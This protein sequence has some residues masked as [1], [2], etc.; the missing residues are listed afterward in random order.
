MAEAA[1]HVRDVSHV[2]VEEVDERDR[3]RQDETAVEDAD[4]DQLMTTMLEEYAEWLGEN[5]GNATHS[6]AL[7]TDEEMEAFR[8]RI[9]LELEPD[10][11]VLP[12]V[13][14]SSS[15]DE[16]EDDAGGLPDIIDSSSDEEA[17]LGRATCGPARAPQADN[18]NASRNVDRKIRNPSRRWRNRVDRPGP[19]ERKIRPSLRR[20]GRGCGCER[21][22]GERGRGCGMSRSTSG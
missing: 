16:P 3:R 18:E 2:G 6:A 8:C 13:I 19:G 7:M 11:E 14:L 21:R 15:T 22:G 10:Y 5:P 20:H 1:A 12:D 17:T 4:I 9:E